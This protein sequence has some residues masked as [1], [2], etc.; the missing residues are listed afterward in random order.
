MVVFCP[1]S[2]PLEKREKALFVVDE[3]SRS[4][5]SANQPEEEQK[6]VKQKSVNA[7]RDSSSSSCSEASYKSPESQE[8]MKGDLADNRRDQNR[9]EFVENARRGPEMVP[10]EEVE[11]FPGQFIRRISDQ[12]QRPRARSAEVGE[13]A[14]PIIQ[15]PVESEEAPQE[16][17]ETFI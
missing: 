16:L 9:I 4:E 14:M 12:L 13:R 2:V 7:C 17:N 5:G 10:A 8:E 6:M 1:K 11:A 3:D 15:D